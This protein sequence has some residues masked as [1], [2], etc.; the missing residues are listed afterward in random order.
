MYITEYFTAEKI[1]M[2]DKDCMSLQNVLFH[3]DIGPF[4]R[5]DTF[6]LGNIGVSLRE[7]ALNLT[8]Y[9]KPYELNQPNE[10]IDHV[11][12]LPF[13]VLGINKNLSKL[14]ELTK[15]LNNA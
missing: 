5:G 12:E 1:D 3:K 15:F 8:M 14:D 13:K 10:T 11:I 4:K 6:P 9:P 2:L 7:M